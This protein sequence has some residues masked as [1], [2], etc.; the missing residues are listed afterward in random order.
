MA[1]PRLKYIQ[2]RLEQGLSGWDF[3]PSVDALLTQSKSRQILEDFFK[4]DGPEKLLFFCQAPVGSSGGKC[5]LQFSTGRD[6]LL[7]GKCCFFTRVN[8]KGIDLK[9]FETDCAYGEIIGNPLN[10][11]E[12][13]INEMFKP[14]L[15]HQENWGKCKDESVKEYRGHVEKFS[16][17]LQEAA[18]SLQKVEELPMPDAK[19][20]GIGPTSTAFAKAAVESDVVTHFEAI[21]ERWCIKQKRCLRKS[22][23]QQRMRRMSG[24]IRSSSFGGGEWRDLI[25]LRSSSRSLLRVWLLV[26]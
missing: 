11:F 12:T 2:E 1:D 7:T 17:L 25:T 23:R 3:S 10:S 4:P 16:S 5:K 19:Y 8:T 13:L 24:Q 9:T 26:F 20:E 6:E 22:N 21:V 14:T 18:A 15:E